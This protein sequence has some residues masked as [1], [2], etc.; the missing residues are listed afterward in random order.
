MTASVFLSSNKGDRG[1]GLAS[2]TWDGEYFGAHKAKLLG[3]SE[4]PDLRGER[5]APHR[6]R[7]IGE[8]FEW[9]G[10]RDQGIPGGVGR[11][12][13]QN[14]DNPI[15]GSV[16]EELA[17]VLHQTSLPASTITGVFSVTRRVEP[18]H[19]L[20]NVD[21]VGLGARS[22]LLWRSPDV[23]IAGIGSHVVISTELSTGDAGA[24]IADA[25]RVVAELAG[26]DDV[27]L[28]G[29][30]PLAFAALPFEGGRPD[31]AFVPEIVVGEYGGDRFVTSFTPSGMPEEVEDAALVH[32]VLAVAERPLSMPPDEIR[33]RLDR[34]AESWR[35]DVVA[36]ARDT[37]R[38]TGLEKAV[39]ARA[40]TL[41]A[42]SLL[43][44]ASVI[45]R[46][47]QRF[48]TALVFSI[49]GFVGASPELLVSRRDRTVRAHPLAGTTARCADPAEDA[50]AVAALVGSSKDRTEHQI[51]ID[52]LLAELLSFCSYVDAEPEP[53]V[54]TLENV[55]HLGTRVEGVLSEPPASVLELV[56]AVHP[57]PAVG[58]SPQGDALKLI[59][60]LE[61]I[62]RG[63]YAGPAG[64]F[65]G[66]GNGQFAV[67]V[68][69]AQI[70]G[71]TARIHAGVGVVAQSDPQAELEETQAK[72]RAMLG[73]FL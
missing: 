43:D 23:V 71:S 39:F 60:E 2:R 14:V 57:T 16:Y 29:T 1:F 12:V 11:Q 35:D 17:V 30:G 64:W 13:G 73:A 56:A 33:L 63:R 20:A 53:S 9:L 54:V 72:F 31:L 47:A 22:G 46:V 68:R 67:A 27:D 10:R 37:L 38:N 21:L 19:G 42:S 61:G 6:A 28:P 41:E 7:I 26:H 36:V 24:S 15:E 40:L 55:H 48:S 49:D 58:G 34:S 8:L 32:Q 5:G 62:D 25:Q 50:Q 69:T 66:Q 52:W 70:D 51:T 59:S 45:E 44:P 18:G 3:A 65:D 4:R